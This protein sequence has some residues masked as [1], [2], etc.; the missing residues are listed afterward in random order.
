MKLMPELIEKVTT[1]YDRPE[2]REFA[3]L[4]SVQEFECYEQVPGGRRTKIPRVEELIQFS[5]KC[6]YKKLGIAFCTGL[7]NEARILTD[8]LENKGFE[9]VSVRCKVGAT[10]KERI[11]IREEEKIRGPGWL[12]SM[13]SPIVQAEILNAVKVDMAIMLGLCIGHDTLF[14]KY[15]RVPLTVLA[16]KDRVFGHNPLAALYLANTSYYGRLMAKTED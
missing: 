2:V 7:A 14:I 13:C 11:G 3:R 5:H 6:N 4:A 12:E 1:E 16:V 10:P 8:I 9:V 15:C